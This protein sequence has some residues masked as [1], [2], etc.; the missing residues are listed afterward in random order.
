MLTRVPVL[1]GKERKMK[2]RHI[3]RNE[4]APGA[5]LTVNGAASEG[6]CVALEAGNFPL[7][8][9]VAF[10][11]YPAWPREVHGAPSFHY[12]TDSEGIL[13]GVFTQAGSLSSIGRVYI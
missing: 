10:L 12:S 13:C 6:V 9:Q 2:Q 5:A 7:S 3:P 4:S 8:G 1:S 11:Q